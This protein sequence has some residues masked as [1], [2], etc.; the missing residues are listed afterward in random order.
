M[1]LDKSS[2]VNHRSDVTVLFVCLHGSAKSLIAAEHLNRLAQ[3]R[4]LAMRGESAGVEPDAGVPAPVVAGL[5][6]DGIDVRGYAPRQ[7]T[8]ERLSTAA[9]IVSFGCDL[10]GM[11]GVSTPV[12]QWDD[13]P[14][15]SDGYDAARDAIVARV[16]A[17][18]SAA[19]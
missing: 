8:A 17:F 7:V 16:T 14:M 13:L 9:H 2:Q 12:L 5:A 18:V 3:V 15:V 10:R 1:G 11:L 19:R 4:G 6:G